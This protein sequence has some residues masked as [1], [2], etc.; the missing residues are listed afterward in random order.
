MSI[1]KTLKKLKK[2]VKTLEPFKSHKPPKPELNRFY[3][4][5]NKSLV[6]IVERD[7]D[8]NTM[9][10]VILKGGFEHHEAGD[11]YWVNEK[12]FYMCG[13]GDASLVLS[14]NKKLEGELPKV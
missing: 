4:T 7:S 5:L 1:K 12:G 10:A 2:A 13:D 9:K 11:Y 6:C 8:D 14:L 3:S